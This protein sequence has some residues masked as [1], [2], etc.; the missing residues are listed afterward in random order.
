MLVV[1][2][3]LHLSDSSSGSGLASGAIQLLTDRLCDLAYRA[4]W[5]ASGMYVP[6]DRIDLLLLGDTL[7]ITGSRQWLSSKARPWSDPAS[8]AFIEAVTGITDD[9]LRHNVDSVRHLRSLATEGLV[10]VPYVGPTGQPLLHEEELP[11]AIRTHYM[12]GNRDWPLHLSHPAMD[13]LRHK[14]A[15][16][17]GLANQHNKPFPHEAVES[18]ELADSLR[19]HRVLARHGDIFDP[20]S[21]SDDRDTASLSDAIAVELIGKFLIRC[22]TEIAGDLSPIAMSTISEI[23]QIRPQLLI[24][25]WMESQLERLIPA[26]ATRKAI[27]RLWDTTVDDFLELEIV[28]H[29]SRWSAVDL[30]DGLAASLKFSR[31]DSHDWTGK[32][33]AWLAD[34]RGAHSGSYAM[35]ALAES[36]FRNRRARHIVYGHTHSAEQIPL[37]ASHADGFVLSQTYF[38]AGTWRRTYQPTQALTGQ[39]EFISSDSFHLLAFYQQ[40]ERSGRSHETL[41]GTLAPSIIESG[42]AP[43][44]P[45]SSSQP[46][47]IRAPHFSHASIGRSSLRRS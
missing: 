7:D 31:R 3:D 18:E 12:V 27:K 32:T 34:L 22:E 11:V 21:F 40:D 33:L 16:H 17:L 36:D 5:R 44:A 43:A 47:T 6:V 14:V 19:R 2:S 29:G 42:V 24:A 20:L 13:L 37:D 38:N 15:H 35:H 26:L 23:E 28:R 10:S 45:I 8:P 4:S 9:I 39:H 30:V 1:L 25:P 46:H 41:S